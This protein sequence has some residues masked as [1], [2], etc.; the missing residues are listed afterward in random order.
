MITITGL[1]CLPL[2]LVAFLG[3]WRLM[4]SMLMAFSTMNAAAVVMIGSFGLSPGYYMVLLVIGRVLMEA[5]RGGLPIPRELVPPLICLLLFLV[6]ALLSL[7]AA[8]VFFQGKVVVLGGGDGFQLALA[9]P[10]QFRRENVTQLAYLAIS[11]TLAALLGVR[12]SKLPPARLA[13]SI[14]GAMMYCI[15]FC[16]I[17]CTWHWLS[18]AAP[19][20][21][22]PHDFFFSNPSYAP[23]V[24]Q[25]M[26][27][28]VRLSGPFSEP[29][30]LAVAYS[31]FLFYTYQRLRARGTVASMILLLWCVQ[32][33]ILSKSST[34]FLL[35]GIFAVLV[36][37]RPLA[38]AALGKASMPRVTPAGVT[39][40]LAVFAACIGIM[41]YVSENR[42]FV[43]TLLD[44]LIFKKQ[45]GIS[46]QERNATNI[47]ALQILVETWGFGIGI[48][49]HK[50]SSFLLT[51]IS[52][53]GITGTLLFLVFLYHIMAL[54]KVVLHGRPVATPGDALRWSIVGTLIPLV[55]SGPNLSNAALWTSLGLELALL[56]A[57][58]TA[59]RSAAASRSA[60]SNRTALIIAAKQA[61]CCEDR[62]ESSYLDLP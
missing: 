20:V 8:V 30:A 56:G 13:S 42:D 46:Y 34:S 54:P 3:S 61:H 19:F 32:I 27:D 14:D 25:M 22:W 12:L 51:L 36:V 4:L 15:V 23:R 43:S 11:V 35:L 6:I 60:P 2:G 47:M 21:R 53:V 52:N 26:F 39:A 57:L 58:S 10:F 40:I 41:W 17:L 50:A 1:V 9:A 29:S 33:L 37:A 7:W 59:Q 5:L 44:T 18:Y 49:S 62:H 48:G 55:I 28:S 31:G 24:D 45:E 16:N 38:L